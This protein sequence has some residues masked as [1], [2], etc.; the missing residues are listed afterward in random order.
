[1]NR[2]AS[3]IITTYNHPQALERCLH[4]VAQQQVLPMEIIIADDGS[5]LSTKAVIDR[6]AR[7]CPVPVIHIWQ[8][9]DGFRLSQIRNKAIAR[10]SGRYI[11]QIDGDVLVH[12]KF[13]YDHLRMAREGY[14]VVGSRVR[15]PVKFSLAM[16]AS[17]AHPSV[18]QLSWQGKD[19]LNALRLPWLACLLKR[20]Y[21][22]RG[23]H[24]AYAKG[25]NMAF[26]RSDLLKVNGYNEQ[27]R[28]WGS[29]DE[30]LAIRLAKAGC[31]KLFLKMS[32]IVYH[33]WH[34]A[35]PR[36]R[37]EENKRTMQ[38]ALHSAAYRCVS[39]VDQYLRDERAVRAIIHP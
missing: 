7:A 38:Q 34:K 8:Q 23:R 18:R 27:I 33:I 17:G 29:E 28:G 1:M 10:A 6:Y 4:Y 21:K 31:R 9:D 35:A 13:I 32:G 22:T 20:V 37:E 24:M 12:P 30:E 5:T 14:F 11:I 26:W 2:Q 15:L 39:G 3:L 19:K 25:C 36:D 16:L